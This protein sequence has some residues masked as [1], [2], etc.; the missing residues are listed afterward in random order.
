MLI[1]RVINVVMSELCDYKRRYDMVEVVRR[2][3]LLLP[4]RIAMGNLLFLV[5][6]ASKLLHHQ[7]ISD[8]PEDELFLACHEIEYRLRDQDY[9]CGLA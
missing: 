8:D 4:A 9:L 5:W 1:P 3:W 6:R 7:T 2:E